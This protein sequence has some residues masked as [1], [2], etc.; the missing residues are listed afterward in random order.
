[1]V[2]ASTP[3][4]LPGTEAKLVDWAVEAARKR[5][6]EGGSKQTLDASALEDDL[7]RLRFLDR[8]GFERQKE[9][10]LLYAR[11]LT[12]PL[13]EPR[14][15][16]GFCIR[17]MKAETEIEA[18]VELHRAAFSAGN[19]SIEYRRAIMDAPGYLPELDLVAVALDGE[20]ASF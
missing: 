17:L 8:H 20:L 12:G 16:A 7:P 5:N 13:P 10:S 9:A 3:I 15:P 18:Y 11:S 14:L 2:D 19:M 4:F 1:L 6:L